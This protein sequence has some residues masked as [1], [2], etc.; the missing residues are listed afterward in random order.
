MEHNHAVMDSGNNITVRCF[1]RMH[2]A[3]HGGQECTFGYGLWPGFCRQYRQH[4]SAT[5]FKS[6]ADAYLSG[7][8]SLALCV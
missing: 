7:Y 2:E 3:A 6:E 1:F 8:L 5:H 4:L